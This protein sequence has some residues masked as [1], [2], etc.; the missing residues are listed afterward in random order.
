MGLAGQ[1]IVMYFGTISDKFNSRVNMNHRSTDKN[2]SEERVEY[3]SMHNYYLQHL[4][5]PQ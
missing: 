3:K 4:L 1:T 2:I 5:F